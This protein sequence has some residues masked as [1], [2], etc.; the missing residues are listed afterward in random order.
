[1]SIWKFPPSLEAANAFN[2]GTAVDALGIEIVEIGPDY[3]RGRMP[4]DARHV[5]PMRL[6]HGGVSVVLAESLGS[7]AAN[8]C[9]D[10]T[11]R[12]AVGLDINANHVASVREGGAVVGT[13]KALHIGGSTQVWEIRIEDE[14]SGRLVCVSRLTMA[15]RD[16]GHTGGA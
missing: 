14:A 7:M 16:T 15:V 3:V 10:P 13:A 12:F 6:L 9:L 2:A 11:E 4:V 1:M 8:F 5:Q